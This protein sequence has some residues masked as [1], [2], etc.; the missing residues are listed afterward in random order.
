MYYFLG[1]VFIDLDTF[2][3]DRHV[4]FGGS[5]YIKVIM[6]L[7]KYGN[8]LQLTFHLTLYL[9]FRPSESLLVKWLLFVQYSTFRT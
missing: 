4:L 9:P 8:Y 6:H 7:G 5:T 3:C 2:Y 1:R